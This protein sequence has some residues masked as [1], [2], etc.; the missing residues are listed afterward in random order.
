MLCNID[1]RWIAG[2]ARRN[3]CL[4]SDVDAS[5]QERARRQDHGLRSE[6]A[7]VRG[8]HA[9]ELIS[10]N[11]QSRDHPLRELEKGERFEQMAHGPL[12][13]RSE[14]H[15]S[16]LQSRPHLVCRLL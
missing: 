4:R 10:L 3:L 9:L 14:E 7:A 16:E 6:P 5:T 1:G 15:T 2:T 13:E 12:V 8:R 11:E